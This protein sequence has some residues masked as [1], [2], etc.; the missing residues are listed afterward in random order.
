MS[1]YK[2]R[3]YKEPLAPQDLLAMLR[4]IGIEAPIAVIVMLSE[5][6]QLRWSD[7]AWEQHLIASDNVIRRKLTR[8]TSL[9][10]KW[11]KP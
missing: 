8:P 1:V 9:L 10:M 5:G 2:S 6:M 4:L 3:Y 11:G 7:W